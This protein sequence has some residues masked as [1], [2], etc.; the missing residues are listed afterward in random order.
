MTWHHARRASPH[1]ALPVVALAA[2]AMLVP[3]CSAH[4]DSLPELGTAEDYLARRENS[5]YSYRDASYDVCAAND[6]YCFAPDWYLVPIYY[7]S[8]ADGDNDCDDGN[9]RGHSV[10]G[11]HKAATP[12]KQGPGVA[13]TTSPST[14]AAAA[15]GFG[16]KVSTGERA[17][18]GPSFVT[19]GFGGRGHR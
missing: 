16:V 7:L 10:G 4:N 12:S 5:A 8:R 1:L 14:L 2:L 18:F 17:H 13:M 9:C 11:H 6:P 15:N 19:K 3:G